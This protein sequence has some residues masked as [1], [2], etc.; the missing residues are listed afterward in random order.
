MDAPSPDLVGTQCIS[1]I[2]GRPAAEKKTMLHEPK[3]SR[4][5]G[6]PMVGIQLR[7]LTR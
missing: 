5:N 4:R 2:D 3:K 7:R 6:I 1:N